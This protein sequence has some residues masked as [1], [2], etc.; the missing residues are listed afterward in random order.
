MISYNETF[1]VGELDLGSFY[2]TIVFSLDEI[3]MKFPPAVRAALVLMDGTTGDF[4]AFPAVTL[5][6]R[7]YGPFDNFEYATFSDGVIKVTVTNNLTIPVSGL[8]IQLYNAAGSIPV[9]DP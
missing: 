5:D 6:E 9:G 4:P 8:N 3:S 7:T 2:D 1:T